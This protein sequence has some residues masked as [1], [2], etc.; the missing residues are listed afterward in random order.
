[1]RGEEVELKPMSM[2]PSMIQ[3]E[4]LLT[5]GANSSPAAASDFDHN[6]NTQK[7]HNESKNKKPTLDLASEI[8]YFLPA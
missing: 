4:A 7:H 8:W 1:V 2:H 6:S 3:T 5:E